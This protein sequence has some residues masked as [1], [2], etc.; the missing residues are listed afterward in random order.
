MAFR[1]VSYSENAKI[2]TVEP[3]RR[4]ADIHRIIWWFYEQGFEKYAV[5]FKLGCYTGL[6]ASDILGLKVK[7][8]SNKVSVTIREQ[9]T[10]KVKQFP[11]N[12]NVRFLLQEF[13]TAHHLQPD[14]YIFSGRGGKNTEADRS[15]VYRFIVRACEELHIEANVGTHTMRKTFGYHHYRQFKNIA[16]LQEIF[17]HASPD[18]TLRYIG[19]TQDEINETYLKLDLENDI[20]SLEDIALKKGDNRTKLRAVIS[21]CKNYLHL[22]GS[23]AIYAPPLRMILDIIYNTHD[24]QRLPVKKAAT[25]LKMNN[26]NSDLNKE[27]NESEKDKNNNISRKE[28]SISKRIAEGFESFKAKIEAKRYLHTDTDDKDNSKVSGMLLE[29]GED[30]SMFYNSSDDFNDIESDDDYNY[31]CEYECENEEDEDEDEDEYDE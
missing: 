30:Y 6:R 9:K 5:L 20:E 3:I 23:E 4:K 28:R 29:D 14:D 27:D 10:G 12:E 22:I 15:Q 21:F 11:L 31:D 13:I 1:K 18:V 19:I 25:C 16:L 17:N 2:S 8:C 26:L 7:D 24:Y